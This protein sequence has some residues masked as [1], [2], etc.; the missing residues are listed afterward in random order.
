MNTLMKTSLVWIALAVLA[1]AMP[2]SAREV[3]G[4]VRDQVTGAPLVAAT[5]IIVETGDMVITNEQGR[6]YFPSITEG[7]YTV[8]IGKSGYVPSARGAVPIRA[9][10]CQ[11]TVGDANGAD[12][13]DPTLG[14]I[15]TLVDAKFITG[16]CSGTIP[17]LTEADVNQSGGANPTC[18]DITLG[19]IMY[20]V[21]YLFITGSSRGL[22]PCL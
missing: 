5:V 4:L 10:C 22:S 16:T 15:M 14:D 20:L 8:L 6:F 13:N 3:A 17:C 18:D 9:S 2:A 7:D 12:G 11:G 1:L 19:D 21:D